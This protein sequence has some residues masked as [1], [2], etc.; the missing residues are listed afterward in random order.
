MG[1]YSE[2][3]MLLSSKGLE[4]LEKERKK[5]LNRISAN[6]AN[7]ILV[8]ASDLS[9]RPEKSRAPISI[10]FTDKLAITDLIGSLGN[11]DLDVIIETYGGS[12]EIVE[13]IVEILRCK[14]KG[15]ISFIVPGCAKSAGTIMVMSGDEILMGSD[16]TLGPIDAQVFMNGKFISADACIAG[17]DDIKEEV[18]KSGR[19]NPAYI[20]I[21]QGLSPGEIKSWKIAQKFASYLVSKWLVSYKFRNW[22][23]HS[24]NGIAVTEEE[25]IARAGEIAVWLTRHDVWLTHA[26]SIKLEDLKRIGLLVNDYSNNADL[27]DAIS[28]YYVLLRILFEVTPVYKIFETPTERIIRMLAVQFQAAQKPSKSRQPVCVDVQCPKCGEKETFCR[29]NEANE[30]LPENAIPFPA[31]NM[32]KCRKC[33]FDMNLSP[34]K[35]Q[36]DKF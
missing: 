17:L 28:R 31:D 30:P 36:L 2:Y 29:T 11:T 23:H 1:I 9:G 8:I 13:D 35:E 6:R 10:D 14:F 22:R 33:G 32:H 12:A 7:D 5:Q 4:E 16:S 24:T 27:N 18:S 20:P 21:L 3:L 19:L 26:R 25:K 15:N 34:I